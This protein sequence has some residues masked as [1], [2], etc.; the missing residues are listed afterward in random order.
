MEIIDSNKMK[1]AKMGFYNT[2]A[3]VF[4]TT[5]K[6]GEVINDFF[7]N[8]NTIS[9]LNKQIE[10]LQA[11]NNNLEFWKNKAL[12]KEAENKSLKN[13][14]K[15]SDN[16]EYNFI[17][18]KIAIN[19]FESYNRNGIIKAKNIQENQTVMSSLGLVGK[20]VKTGNNFANVLLITDINSKVPVIIERNR[21]KAIVYGQNDNNKLLLKYLSVDSDAMIGD[22]IITSGD[23][24]IFMPGLLVGTIVYIDDKQV[25]VKP[26]TDFSKLEV[27][28]ILY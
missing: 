3:P 14:L 28:S 7:L 9:N 17:S 26:A 18:S 12:S 6:T 16:W 25:L 22:R 8:F 11:E 19:N 10:A 13:L 24:S 20:I 1:S 5:M 15:Y 21:E 27:V 2:M 4:H 23:G